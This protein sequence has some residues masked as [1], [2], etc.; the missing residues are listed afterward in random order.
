MDHSPV[1]IREN[2]INRETHGY[3]VYRLGWDNEKSRTGF[4]AAFAQ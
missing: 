2:H 1:A 3:S 4:E